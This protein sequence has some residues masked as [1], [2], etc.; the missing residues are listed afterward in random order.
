MSGILSEIFTN[1]VTQT[2]GDNQKHIYT[3]DPVKSGY[4]DYDMGSQ[5]ISVFSNMT[6]EDQRTFNILKNAIK[7]LK[8]TL[9]AEGEEDFANSLPDTVAI[10]P[11][12]VLAYHA[13]TL[14]KAPLSNAE[15]KRTLGT[16]SAMKGRNPQH[17]LQ[18]GDLSNIIG[19][20]VK[21]LTQNIR[22]LAGG[23]LEH[24][25]GVLNDIARLKASNEPHNLATIMHHGWVTGIKGGAGDELLSFPSN[26][27]IVTLSSTAKKQDADIIKMFANELST[28]TRTSG[29]FTPIIDGAF[30]KSNTPRVSEYTH[31]KTRNRRELRIGTDFVAGLIDSSYYNLE[32]F[33]ARALNILYRFVKDIGI[34]NLKDITQV[35]VKTAIGKLSDEDKDILADGIKTKSGENYSDNS[36]KLMDYYNG[37]VQYVRVCVTRDY[38]GNRRQIA[39]LLN[40]IDELGSSDDKSITAKRNQLIDVINTRKEFLRSLPVPNLEAGTKDN[41]TSYAALKTLLKSLDEYYNALDISHETPDKQIAIIQ[42]KLQAAEKK[43]P[44][45]DLKQL[46]RHTHGKLFKISG[47]KPKSGADMHKAF[48]RFQLANVSVAKE[49]HGKHVIIVDDNISTGATVKDAIVSLY[50][51]GIVPTSIVVLAPHRLKYSGKFEI[52]SAINPG[53]TSQ[54]EWNAARRKIEAEIKAGD[55]ADNLR[56]AQELE[57]QIDISNDT[58]ALKL[59]TLA[60]NIATGKSKITDIVKAQSL[61]PDIDDYQKFTHIVSDLSTYSKQYDDWFNKFIKS[62]ESSKSTGYYV[63]AT[64]KVPNAADIADRI[65]FDFPEDYQAKINTLTPY[66]KTNDPELKRRVNLN[67][68]FLNLKK[69]LITKRQAKYRLNISNLGV[70]LDRIGLLIGKGTTLDDHRQADLLITNLQNATNALKPPMKKTWQ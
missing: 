37:L 8:V 27:V 46:Y 16:L 65:S 28:Q 34:D 42:K 5:K 43:A 9:R 67:I 2:D 47:A 10:P 60:I 21:R 58:A 40:Q 41:K 62:L 61:I 69:D 24:E 44:L 48:S 14:D 50:I 59:A 66:L 11:D 29:S 19:S 4:S 68:R 53:V 20:S 6:V 56:L 57:D 30:F 52:S 22:Q 33:G 15:Y 1:V 45:E 49:L 51:N 12:Y 7:Q 31:T 17:V 35:K 39:S 25:K 64:P 3:F 26:S 23:T 18:T 13:Y 55:E 38:D 36:T 54:K 70:T 63:S 32:T